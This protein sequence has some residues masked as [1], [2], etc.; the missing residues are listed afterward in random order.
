VTLAVT[1]IQSLK[2]PTK[3]TPRG[4]CPFGSKKHDEQT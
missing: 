1:M 3:G 2:I 4:A